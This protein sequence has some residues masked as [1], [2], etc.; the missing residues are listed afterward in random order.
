MMPPTPSRRGHEV[1]RWSGQPAW[2][3]Y[4]FLW[5]ITAVFGVRTGLS[6][7]WGQ[8]GIVVIHVAGMA[9]FVCL[10]VFFRR[11]TK[12]TLTQEAIYRSAGMFGRTDERLPLSEVASVDVGRSRLDQLLGIGTV[13]LYR[14]DGTSD[15]LAGLKDPE[16]IQRKIEA[17]LKRPTASS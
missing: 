7:W 15:R 9:V 1:T 2:S 12:Y 4:I 3:Q 14:E 16:V 13:L 10:A 11:T 17:L 8:W 6:V 5:F